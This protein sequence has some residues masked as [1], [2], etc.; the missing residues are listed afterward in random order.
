MMNRYTVAAAAVLFAFATFGTRPAYA[1]SE[2]YRAKLERSGCSQMNAGHGCDINKTKAQNGITPEQDAAEQERVRKWHEE[3]RAAMNAPTPPA[4]AKEQRA[5]LNA[6]LEE[7]V[8]AQP[9]ERAL[10]ALKALGFKQ[11][12]GEYVNQRGERVIVDID[13]AQVVRTVTVK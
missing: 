13:R 9:V 10:N 8:L 2:G 11:T 6:T 12:H 1:I 4:E 3:A 7:N 5:I